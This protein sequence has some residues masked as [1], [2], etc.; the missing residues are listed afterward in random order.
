MD[1]DLLR[2]EIY[3]RLGVEKGSLTSESGND[4]QRAK[5]EILEEWKAKE[6]QKN[7]NNDELDYMHLSKEST[8]FQ[9]ILHDTSYVKQVFKGMLAT[10]NDLIE[11]E[12]LQLAKTGDKEVI[13]YLSRQSTLPLSVIDI[14]ISRGTYMAKK[15]LVEHHTLSTEQ[16]EVLLAHFNQHSDTYDTSLR[17]RL[18]A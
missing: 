17:S 1:E 15:T 7:Q 11:D 18:Q 14:I 9:T 3:K 12:M 13:I 2:D 4:W 5:N 8:L 10:R 6:Q 16:K